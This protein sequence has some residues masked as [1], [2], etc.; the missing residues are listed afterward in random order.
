MN[1]ASIATA[2][3]RPLILCIDDADIGLRVRKWL[4][5]SAGYNVLTANTAE[6]GFELSSRIP[7]SW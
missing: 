1:S 6:D 4:F 3:K 7:A 5:A 2:A